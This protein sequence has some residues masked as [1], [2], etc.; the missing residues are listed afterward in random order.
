MDCHVPFPS[1]YGLHS[2]IF[3]TFLIIF[4]SFF[5]NDIAELE[6]KISQYA[7]SDP[8]RLNQLK[9]GIEIS[10]T[11]A[12]RWTGR[13]FCLI[14]CSYINYFIFSFSCFANVF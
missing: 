10:K 14:I 5:R 7:D 8:D 11:S 6:K 3:P 4:F 12:D 13:F 1:Y 9:K 2:H